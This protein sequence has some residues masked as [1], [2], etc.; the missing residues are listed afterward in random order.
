MYCLNLVDSLRMT[1]VL[2]ILVS[3][4]ENLTIRDL[5]MKKELNHAALYR[6]IL[7]EEDQSRCWRI[8]EHIYQNLL[9]QSSDNSISKSSHPLFF[10]I[11]NNQLLND[12]VIVTFYVLL[13]FL[14]RNR[15][16]KRLGL[17]IWCVFL[18][19]FIVDHEFSNEG[20]SPLGPA[21]A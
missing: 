10:V 21:S 14:K 3:A 13:T 1:G 5:K 18:A 12:R 6:N 7:R 9:I 4:W 20:T 17:S 11:W 16:K 15:K 19:L 8:Q 2:I